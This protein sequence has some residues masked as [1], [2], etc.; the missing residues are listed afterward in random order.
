MTV[1]SCILELGGNETLRRKLSSKPLRSSEAFRTLSVTFQPYRCINFLNLYLKVFRWCL[2]FAS[3][4]W[5]CVPGKRHRDV[6]RSR[7]HIHCEYCAILELLDFNWL[8]FILFFYFILEFHPPPS[9][10]VLKIRMRAYHNYVAYRKKIRYNHMHSVYVHA[11][12][13]H[14]Y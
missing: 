5:S 2:Y 11:F 8:K 6:G 9:N 1:D 12:Q 14:R 10:E 3:R 13:V 7:V 4:R